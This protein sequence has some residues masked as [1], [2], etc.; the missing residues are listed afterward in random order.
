MTA[1][2]SFF[3]L[4]L[5]VLCLCWTEPA[6]SQ[7]GRV[8]WVPDGDSLH[9][10]DGRK[11]RL[12]G[13]DAPEMGRDGA[14]EQYFARESRDYLRRLVDGRPIRLE[15]DGHGTD[16]YNRVLACAYLSDGRMINEV[17]VEEGLAFFYPHPGQNKEFQE[18]LLE[19]QKR[20]I[21][22][23]KGFWP[24]ILTLPQPQSGWVGNRRSK[25]FHHPDSHYTNR[26]SPKNRVS[27][28]SLEQAFSE[29]Y[30]PAR[31]SSPWPDADPQ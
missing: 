19:V 20:A 29:G 11:V 30:A 3:H 22:S 28:F 25:R 8:K 14:P 27:L 31:S 7:E 9:M 23:R 6:M 24:R 15:T 21:F 2:S 17:L 1:R 4:L 5:I 10:E 16:R 12:M 26:I 13:I 18:R